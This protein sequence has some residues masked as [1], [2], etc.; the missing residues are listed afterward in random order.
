MAVRNPSSEP[1]L[2]LLF[3]GDTWLS[4]CKVLFF[5]WGVVFL[6][7]QGVPRYK[8]T[9]LVPLPVFLDSCRLTANSPNSLSF[10][11]TL[12]NRLECSNFVPP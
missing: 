1:S 7:P 8:A 9:V 11:T 2:V 12:A 10:V 5:H 6:L 3:S 4:I